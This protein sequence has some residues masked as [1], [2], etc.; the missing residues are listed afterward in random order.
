[1]NRDTL[2][3]NDDYPVMNG[4]IFPSGY[5]NK[6]NEN[7]NTIILIEGGNSCGFVNFIKNK[8]WQGGNCYSILTKI[9]KAFLFQ[10]L[11]YNEK[12]IMS[13]RV[14]SGLPNIQRSRLANFEIYLPNPNEQVYISNILTEMDA[15]VDIREN[16]LAKALSKV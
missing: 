10:Y 4:G 14:G 7:S 9:D 12:S 8:F 5:T 3:E 2:N 13:L 6:L 1:M 16:Q 11:K 15:E